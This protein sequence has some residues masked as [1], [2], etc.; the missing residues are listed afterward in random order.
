MQAD[1]IHPTEAAQP[2]IMES[3]WQA[4]QSLL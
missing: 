4:L 2:L 1:G 3:V